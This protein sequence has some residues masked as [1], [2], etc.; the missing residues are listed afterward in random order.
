MASASVR[1]TMSE[2]SFALSLRCTEKENVTEAYLLMGD[3][4]VGR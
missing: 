2:D 4:V 3:L 1:S